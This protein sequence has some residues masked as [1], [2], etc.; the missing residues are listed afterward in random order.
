MRTGLRRVSRCTGPR[1]TLA[2]ETSALLLG[3]AARALL[4][5]TLRRRPLCSGVQQALRKVEA[6][7]AQAMQHRRSESPA[8]VAPST[9][10]PAAA[11]AS[12]RACGATV[13]QPSLPTS[14]TAGEGGVVG[15]GSLRL[16]SWPASKQARPAQRLPRPRRSAVAQRRVRSLEPGRHTAASRAPWPARRPPRAATPGPADQRAS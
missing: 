4:P 11:G 16:S 9:A 10:S 3:R 2:P 12:R 14:T 6:G 15:R 1:H 7:A 13:R 5:S 8:A